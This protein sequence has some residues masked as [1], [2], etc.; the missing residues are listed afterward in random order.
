[1]PDWSKIKRFSQESKDKQMHRRKDGQTYRRTD[2][3]KYIISPLR[4]SITNGNATIL[5]QK[6]CGPHVHTQGSPVR[7]HIKNAFQSHLLPLFLSDTDLYIHNYQ[8]RCTLSVKINYI[9]VQILTVFL[10]GLLHLFFPQFS[11]CKT[12]V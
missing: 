5:F 6:N 4:G 3:T 8:N 1:M 12:K 7:T 9:P 11:L 10:L 2:T